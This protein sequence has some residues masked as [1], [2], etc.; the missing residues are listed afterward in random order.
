MSGTRGPVRRRT[1]ADGEERVGWR[2][3]ASTLTPATSTRPHQ[4]ARWPMV[5]IR[6]KRREEPVQPVGA[7]TESAIGSI[8]GTPIPPGLFFKIQST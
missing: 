1:G 4:A 6:N 7:K 2:I 3:G 8:D 5:T